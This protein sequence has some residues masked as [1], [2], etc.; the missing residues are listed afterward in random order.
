VNGQCHWDTVRRAG[1]LDAFD[2]ASWLLTGL[3]AGALVSALRPGITPAGY[4]ATAIVA[5]ASAVLGGWGASCLS[6]MSALAFLA[7]VCTGVLGAL[8]QAILA[9]RRPPTRYHT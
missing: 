8:L 5:A 4:L 7:A 6:G 1:E 9:Q 2:A 3:V